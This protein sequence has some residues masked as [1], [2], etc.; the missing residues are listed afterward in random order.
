NG[1]FA[2]GTATV[3]ANDT[4]KVFAGDGVK[5]ALFLVTNS[6]GSAFDGGSVLFEDQGKDYRPVTASVRVGAAAGSAATVREID[7][8]GEAA[9]FQTQQLVSEAITV[10]SGSLG[11]VTLRASGGSPANITAPRIVGSIDVT[12]GAISGTIK[13]TEGNLG[14]AIKDA[15][16]N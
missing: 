15:N 9:S 11:D 3:Q 1:L 10:L 5:V 13:T 14:S 8:T 7:L 2:A 12:N 4:Y 6:N 16:G